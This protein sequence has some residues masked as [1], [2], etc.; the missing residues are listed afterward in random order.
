M[1]QWTRDWFSQFVIQMSGS[2]FLVD[3]GTAL[4][5]VSDT[6]GMTLQN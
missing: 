3:L 4:G 2:V 6:R 5:P 1:T